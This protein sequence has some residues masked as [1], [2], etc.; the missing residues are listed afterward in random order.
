MT[1]ELWKPIPSEPGYEASNLGRIRSVDRHV[2]TSKGVRVYRG[3]VLKPGL[4]SNGYFTVVANGRSRLVHELVLLTFVGPRPDFRKASTVSFHRDDVRTNNKLSNLTWATN[5]QNGKNVTRLGG[6]LF[7]YEEA[8]DI[9]RRLASGE[10][11]LDLSKEYGCTRRH[12]YNIKLEA[13]YVE[14]PVAY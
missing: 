6:R 10:T 2:Q 7:S 4:S 1:K 13:Q 5:S 14:D 11:A 9:K 12:I 3:R 8:E